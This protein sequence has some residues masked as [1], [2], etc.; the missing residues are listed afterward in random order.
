[1]TNESPAPAPAP[2]PEIE[3]LLD[4]TPVARK[5]IRS[6]G[7]LPGHQR[8][9]V[10]ALAVLGSPWRAAQE[11]GRTESGAYKLRTSAGGESFAAAW[12]AALALHHRRHPKTTPRGRPSRGE[13]LAIP[14]RGRSYAKAAEPEPEDPRAREA[15]EAELL[16]AILTQYWTKL[17][18]ER[19]ARLDGRIVEA[20]FCVRQLSW[21]EVALSLTGGVGKVMKYLKQGDLDAR[22]IVAT[23]M[24]VLLDGV[25]RDFWREKGEP[26]RPPL[27]ALGFHDQAISRGESTSYSHQPGGPTHKQWCREQ[28]K[29]AALAAQAQRAW[30]EKA[31]ADAEA[32]AKRVEG[33]GG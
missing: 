33:E 21:L 15:R 13:L 31:R 11:V 32:W 3:A 7:W 23:P 25:R 2:D 18:E 4:F 26:E 6:D 28:D 22:R 5:C 16:E 14:H 1:M 10:A 20:D 27:P 24:S 29:A 19:L 30:E 17:K 8:D 12:D 9:F